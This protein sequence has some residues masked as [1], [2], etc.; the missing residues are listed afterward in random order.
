MSRENKRVLRKT[1]DDVFWLDISTVLANGNEKTENDMDLIAK[2]FAFSLEIFERCIFLG[3]HT[4]VLENSDRLFD[5]NDFF[6]N[7]L[8]APGKHSFDL[9]RF[10]PSNSLC[11]HLEN[12]FEFIQN[13]GTGEGM[14]L[15]IIQNW[16][17]LNK[18]NLN[19]ENLIVE[20][21]I[22]KLSLKNGRILA[23]K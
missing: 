11:E 10:N 5:G 9:F 7:L 20:N 6:K 4:I 8:L 16:M 17:T 12:G 18:K 1:F 19:D 3:P 22:L 23:E 15:K 21:G 2:I 14:V 13:N